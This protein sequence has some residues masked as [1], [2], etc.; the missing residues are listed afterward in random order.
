MPTANHPS[1]SFH[2]KPLS[3]AILIAC[4]SLGGTALSAPLSLAQAQTQSSALHSFNIA[5]GNLE[6]A[7]QQFATQ[8]GI[9]LAYSPDQVQG[10]QS[11]GVQGQHSPGNALNA[12]LSGSGLHASA[13]GN[14]SYRLEQVSVA[15]SVSLPSA[16]VYAGKINPDVKGYDDV[17][18]KDISNAYVDREYLERYRGVSAGDV[19]AGMNG[20]YNTDT[21]NA[22]A[23]SPNIR[24]L[25]GNG[26]VPVTVDG[27]EQSV[28][29]FLAQQGVGNR[30]YV[31]PN[32]FRSIAVEKGPSMTRGMKS[33][34]GG[35]VQI[36]TIEAD[37]I[38]T[39]DKDWGLQIKGGTASN[40]INPSFDAHNLVGKDYRDHNVNPNGITTGGKGPFAADFDSLPTKRRTTSDVDRLNGADRNGFIAGAWRNEHLDVL[41]A[42][43][44]AKRGNYFAGKNGVS[45][46]AG[47]ERI[48]G[49]PTQIRSS[50]EL[51]PNIGKLYPGG[52][53]VPFS[54]S[55]NKTLLL[56]GNLKLDNDQ[57]ISLSYQRNKMEFGEQP[58]LWLTNLLFDVDGGNAHKTIDP[59]N[60]EQPYPLSVVEQ[61]IY[62]AAYEYKPENNDWIDLEAA[63]WRTESES[64]R[65]QNG[66]VTYHV[67]ERD[68]AYHNWLQWP[69]FYPNY[70]K[71]ENTD[72]RYSLYFANRQDSQSTRTGVDI[73]NMFSLTDNLS[74]TAAAD[75][76]YEEQED[77]MPNSVSGTGF[78]G[79]GSQVMGPASGRRHEY[80]TSLNLNWQATS[81]LS[82]EAGLRYGGYWSYDDE[83]ANQR[84]AQSHRLWQA[85]INTHQQINYSRLLNQEEINT[86]AIISDLSQIR[87]QATREW[88]NAGRP[89][90]GPIYEDY[91][92]SG[93]K[94]FSAQQALDD[95]KAANNITDTF[96]P[97][98]DEN[99]LLWYTTYAA[100]SMQ[101]GKA[102]SSQ[103]PFYNGTIDVN[104]TV[105]N[106][107][108]VAGS[109]QKYQ[110]VG[111]TT[112]VKDTSGDPW[113]RPD[114]QRA[115][116]WSVQVVASYKLTERNRVYLRYGNMARFPTIM[117]ISN[118]ATNL[119]GIFSYGSIQPERNEAY[120]VGYTYNFAGLLSGIELGDIKLSYYQNSIHDFYDRT[121]DLIMVQYDRKNMSGYEL[122][123]RLDSGRYFASFGLSYRD[124][125]EVCDKDIAV[126]IDPI[127][128]RVPKCMDGGMPG[129]MSFTNMQPKYSANLDLGT[130]LFNE[131][132][133]LGT[134]LRYHSKA[135]ND[136][137]DKVI[138]GGFDRFTGVTRPYY[139][140]EVK[141]VDIYAEVKPTDNSLVRLGVNN[142][143]NRYYLDPLARL[144]SPGPGRTVMLNAEYSF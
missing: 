92:D 31:D 26:R 119:G 43:S 28:D 87:T 62:R 108:G 10:R 103:N 88:R 57:K 55:H 114:T 129:T 120:E 102:D 12:L 65:Y 22:S 96:N 143:T 66:D 36:R 49:S 142:L 1:A 34:V 16:V 8:S 27:T 139:W 89:S 73:S 97:T 4:L 68:A 35:S 144:P 32:M 70:E 80:G 67:A 84:A 42:Y 124:K 71:A 17:F 13:L 5:A 37:D 100:V 61:D 2:R 64:E 121:T 127:H 98:P 115:H 7:L 95:Y 60:V 58:A 41:A 136:Q 128:N 113:R 40:S 131:R 99:G 104:E 105:D 107:Q 130:R 85:D 63:I 134:R 52:Y 90:S 53:E 45:D 86:L 126:Y 112:F 140:D 19:F 116:A 141:L 69:S 72:G 109:Y 6:T 138:A 75:W 79:V 78:G 82:L 51:T 59:D 11:P 91:I 25:S 132:L 125:Q 101:D 47:T 74:L 94:L 111:G 14:G 76:Q 39:G 29:V 15:E 9:S 33:G 56:K 38:I 83:T 135:E 122:Q 123:A 133:M 110:A 20:V 106:P 50:K 54:S 30:S 118:Q 23:L 77:H 24:G 117:E 137:L 3:H 48:A 44:D 81:R 21:R 18:D 93:T 46:Y